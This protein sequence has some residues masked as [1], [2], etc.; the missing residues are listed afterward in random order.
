MCTPFPFEVS[1]TLA[2]AQRDMEL[3]IDEFEAFAYFSPGTSRSGRARVHANATHGTGHLLTARGS[4]VES[5]RCQG[6]KSANRCQPWGPYCHAQPSLAASVHLLRLACAPWRVEAHPNA[7]MWAAALWAQHPEVVHALHA[8]GLPPG[9]V[10]VPVERVPL[11]DGPLPE[12]EVA[13]L[14]PPFVY[15]T[16]HTTANDLLFLYIQYHMLLGIRRYV[17]YMQVQAMP[18][19]TWRLKAGLSW[20]Q[21]CRR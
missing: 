19:R 17:Q 14:L 13:A 8:L 15:P 10:E 12:P 6:N 21:V 4:A 7:Q 5:K 9:S 20:I 3:H 11:P 1:L 16:P 18:H 2:A